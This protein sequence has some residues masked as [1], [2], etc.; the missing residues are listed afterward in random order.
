M[1]P[2]ATWSGRR[3]AYAVGARIISKRVPAEAEAAVRGRRLS[4]DPLGLIRYDG[5][6]RWG[7]STPPARSG[8]SGWW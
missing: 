3:I 4:L 7:G 8:A 1:T 2:G 6:T 5:R